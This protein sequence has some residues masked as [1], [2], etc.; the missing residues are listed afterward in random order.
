MPVYFPLL[1]S[2]LLFSDREQASHAAMQHVLRF[3][4][5]CHGLP[6]DIGSQSDVPRHQ[7]VCQLCG[8]ETHL[9]FEC[10]AMAD[11][12]GQFPDTFKVH[13]TMQQS[14]WQPS[15][16]QIAKFLDA[17]MKRLQMVDPSKGPNI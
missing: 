12:R 5:G 15:L 13:Q 16:W 7:R 3:W 14:M 10:A 2:D 6:K 1:V 11:L 9:V 17:S 4:T 8:N